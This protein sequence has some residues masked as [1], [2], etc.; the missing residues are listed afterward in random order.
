MGIK[1]AKK[2]NIWVQRKVAIGKLFENP[3]APLSPFARG[4]G[5]ADSAYVRAYLDAK[6]K[7][8]SFKSIRGS[9]CVKIGSIFPFDE[10]R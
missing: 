7:R 1:L 10:S 4:S 9:D 5:S 6:P 2:F 3:R 8:K